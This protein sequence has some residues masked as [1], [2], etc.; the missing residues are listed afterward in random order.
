VLEKENKLTDDRIESIKERFSNIKLITLLKEN[1]SPNCEDKIKEIESDLNFILKIN[2]PSFVTDDDLIRLEEISKKRYY[3]L[4]KNEKTYLTEFEKYHLSVR[5]GNFTKEEYDVMKSHVSYTREILKPIPFTDEL[6]NVPYYASQHH[7]KLDG[8][9][10]PDFLVKNQLSIQSRILA[11][12]DIFEALTAADRPY[13]KSIPLDK[14]LAIIKEEA[15]ANK[16]DSDIVNLFINNKVYQKYLDI[17]VT[18]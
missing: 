11:I 13:K 1:S 4:D 15:D 10:Y 6:K 16:L 12:A 14:S 5:R 3:D 7:E 17:R 8:T 2:I 9:G 18:L